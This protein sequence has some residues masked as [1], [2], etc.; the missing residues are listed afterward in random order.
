MWAPHSILNFE[1]RR[2]E[3]ELA[4]AEA[5]LLLS[6]AEV[7]PLNIRQSFHSLAV[8][9]VMATAV[10]GCSRSAQSYIDRGDAQLEAGNAGAAVLEYRNAVGRDP[11]SAPARLKL[12]AAYLRQGNGAGAVSEYVR[13][14]DL[15]PKDVQAQLKAGSLLLLAGRFDD[16]RS[17]SAS[18]FLSSTDS[19]FSARPRASSNR[20][21]SSSSDPAFSC[22]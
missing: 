11:M 19:A 13:V 16:A 6:S 17:T 20:P 14:A 15:L 18:T 21:A 8:I 9:A 22:A 5:A 7:S 12:A 3:P 2:S 10:A 1:C 4:V